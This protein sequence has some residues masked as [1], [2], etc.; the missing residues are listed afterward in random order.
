MEEVLR[1]HE[2]VL[3]LQ[4]ELDRV[5]D[6]GTQAVPRAVVLLGVVVAQADQVIERRPHR[7]GVGVGDELAGAGQLEIGAERQHR[8]RGRLAR[9]LRSRH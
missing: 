9:R 1:R 3:A 5:T 7:R 8:L 2:L 6:A 4:A